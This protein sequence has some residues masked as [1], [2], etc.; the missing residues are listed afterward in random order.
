MLAVKEIDAART[1]STELEE[2]A[3]RQG[4]DAL[5]AMSAH[6]RGA[7]DLA[8]GDPGAALVALRRA[9]QAWQ[10]LGGPYDA[11]RTRVLAG[12]ACRALGDE[13]AALLELEAA[14]GVFAHLEARPDLAAVDSLA[15]VAARDA[16][17]GLTE[18]ERKCFAWSPPGRA[19]TQ[20]L[21]T[22]S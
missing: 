18:R 2:L 3:E 12:L 21:S 17:H 19:T 14:R 1:A 22:C 8:G 16:T 5:H 6:A 10:D 20:S 9:W 11:A 13:D 15:R 7:V 4:S